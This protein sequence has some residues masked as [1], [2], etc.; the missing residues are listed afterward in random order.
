MT[1]IPLYRIIAAPATLTLIPFMQPIE[2]PPVH[3]GQTLEREYLQPRGITQTEF[4]ARLGISFQRVNSLIRGRR[5][6]TPDTAL[7]L[8]RALGVSA[9]EWLRQQL[10]WD[11]YQAKQSPEAREIEEIR[12]LPALT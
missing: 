8:E 6:V 11:L 4:A 7:R 5:G 3:P 12:P 1:Q 2:R 10:E 9:N